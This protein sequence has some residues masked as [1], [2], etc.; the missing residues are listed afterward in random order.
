MNILCICY[1]LCILQEEG[2]P[3]AAAASPT[4]AGI[5]M[6]IHAIVTRLTGLTNNTKHVSMQC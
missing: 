3:A 6:G 5:S 4:R 2:S 1:L